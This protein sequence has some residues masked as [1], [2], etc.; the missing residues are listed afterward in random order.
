[1]KLTADER[2]ARYIFTL[3]LIL[4]LIFFALFFFR[5]TDTLDAK[6]VYTVDAEGYATLKG[7]SAD[8]KTLEIPSEL[9]GYPVRYIDHHAFGG[10][11][12]SLRKVIIPEGVEVIDEYAFANA[13]ELRKVVLPSSLKKIGRGAF[14]NC[15]NLSDIELPAGLL[16]LDAEVFDSCT[17]LG[18]LK[19]PASV[20]KIGVDCFGSC[21]NLRLDVSENPLAAEIAENYHIETGA[22]DTFSVYLTVAIILSV[23]AVVGVFVG[24]RYLKKKLFK[25]KKELS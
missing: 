8:P 22:V 15:S 14:E 20:E 6:F 5:G 1:M 24:G 25:N 21:E 18:A 16:E 10:H 23:V 7:Y 13:P 11:E 2:K 17:R 4:I 9:D 12:S 19:I 3:S